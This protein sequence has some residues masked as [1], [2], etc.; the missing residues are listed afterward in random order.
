MDKY[1]QVV[2]GKKWNGLFYK[3]EAQAETD[4][5]KDLEKEDKNNGGKETVGRIFETIRAVKIDN[6]LVDIPVD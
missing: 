5:L 2:E 3:T 1:A 6:V 4:L